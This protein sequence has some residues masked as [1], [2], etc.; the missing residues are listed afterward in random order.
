L[1]RTGWAPRAEGRPRNPRAPFAAGLAACAAAGA[2]AGCSGCGAHE[3]APA[4]APAADVEVRGDAPHRDAHVVL[5][6][7]DDDPALAA[8]VDDFG[9][10][11]RWYDALEPVDAGPVVVLAAAGEARRRAPA[12]GAGAP[13]LPPHELAGELAAAA[14]AMAP[15]VP[16]AVE[17]PLA[18]VL[19]RDHVEQFRH[20]GDVGEAV[21]G[22]PAD[23]HLVPHPADRFAF[24]FALAGRYVAR[25]EALADLPPYLAAGAA[26]WLS[27]GWYGRPWRD[28][29]PLLAAAEVLPTAEELLAAEEPRDGSRLLWT[30][31]AAAV[32]DRLPGDTLVEKL[33]PPPAPAAVAATLAAISRGADPAAKASAASDLRG[34]AGRGPAGRSDPPAQLAALPP[35][36][37]GVSLAMINDVERG[38]HAPS[39][40]RALDRLAGLGADSVSLMPFA[41]Q[42]APDDPAM[43]YLHRSPG[44]ETDVGMVHAA[45]RAKAHGFTVLWKPQV[46]LRGS[47]PG[48]IGFGDDR[49]AW[50]AWWRAYRRFVVHHAL[51][52][53]WAG[54]DLFAVGTEL[55][56]TLGHEREWRQLVAAV[57]LF[58]PGALTYA[59]N[60]HGDFERVPFWDAL[61][62]LGVDAYRP[63][64]A[65][66]D[67]TP[68]ELAAGAREMARD[69]AGASARH[70]RQVLVTEL[71]YAARRGAW[72]APH[73]EGGEPSEAD[74][75]AAYRA[76]LAALGR[77]PWL[78][79]V[80]LWKAFSSPP[81]PDGPGPR[82]DF[83][84]LGRE[85]EG[86]VA[87]YFRGGLR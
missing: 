72:V 59:A 16:A 64:A 49:E 29:L 10:L 70:G 79:G 33:S 4:P 78:R 74:Q 27:N 41:F 67:A 38:Y 77:E 21:V 84:F 46:W 15:R 24:R 20:A 34:P 87:D 86:V 69:L 61:D 22:G 71:G 50:A 39:V 25:A 65:S 40:D 35:F 43:A 76:A 6:L 3:A 32:V 81:G 13:R 62:L 8:A 45:R 31:A 68:S 36:L 9:D 52:A 85:A 42:R 5:T 63:L 1:A 56:G 73:E 11:A 55:G 37:A 7:L 82:P 17:P 60:W 57:R 80:Y 54:S 58:D 75:A 28:W 2:L 30:P 19:E 53:R 14:R 83:R 66:P 47:W 44:S 48:E 12:G 18:V 51:L 26:L 23:L